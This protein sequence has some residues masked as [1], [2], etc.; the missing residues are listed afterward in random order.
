MSLPEQL[1]HK[2][3]ERGLQLSGGQKQRV[4]IARALYHQPSILIFDEATS[5]LDQE[6]ENKVMESINSLKSEKT[7]VCVAHRISSIRS[8]DC[9]ILLKNGKV[10]DKGT[11]IDLEK[12]HHEY[13]RDYA[14][15][16]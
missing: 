1:N 4:G 10:F 12:R 5:A 8:F 9:L 3:G 2:I 15:E 7:I 13:F 11:Y 14:Q 6:T 16:S